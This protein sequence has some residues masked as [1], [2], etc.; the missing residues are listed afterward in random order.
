MA[1]DPVHFEGISAQTFQSLR[2]A[3]AQAG[4]TVP[5]GTSGT[6]SGGGV[7]AT[8]SWDGAN[9]LKV[10]V[11]D[12]PFLASCNRVNSKLGDFVVKAGGR[13]V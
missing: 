13:R 10:Q 5:L 11:V 1:C 6:I 8:F 2:D 7:T 3:L 9:V 4:I 12:K